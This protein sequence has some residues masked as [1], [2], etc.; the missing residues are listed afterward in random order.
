MERSVNESEKQQ[1]L[2]RLDEGCRVLL[3]SLRGVSAE[4]ALRS[5]AP[6]RWTILECVEHLALSED[7]LLS[8]IAC[9]EHRESS[10]I[11]PQREALIVERAVDRTRRFE[12]PE[13]A[14]R[15]GRFATL[16]AAVEYFLASRE[17]TVGF[18]E[19]NEDDLRLKITTHPLIGVA[20]CQEVLLTMAMH[21]LRHAQQIEEIKAALNQERH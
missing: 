15:T 18:V 10:A 14:R 3:E 9:A 4:A 16:S 6:G 13:V 20:N 19:T 8:Q 12:A 11:P 21:P 5:P 1:M 7:Y 17:R 2:A